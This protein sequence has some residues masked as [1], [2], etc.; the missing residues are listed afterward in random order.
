MTK[1]DS[2]VHQQFHHR[3][4][5][6][7]VRNCFR[8]QTY[9]NFYSKLHYTLFR[10]SKRFYIYTFLFTIIITAY[11]S[12]NIEFGV[13]YNLR[14]MKPET[15]SIINYR[16]KLIS[17]QK[18]EQSD[19]YNW[20]QQLYEQSST[21]KLFTNNQS[22]FYNYIN[23]SVST[24]SDYYLLNYNKTTTTKVTQS[25]MIVITI[26]YSSNG[27]DRQEGKF[28]IGQVLKT[29]LE[30]YDDPRIIV[31][32]CENS[33]YND[34]QLQHI[35]DE[36]KLIRKLVPVYIVNAQAIHTHSLNIELNEYEREKQAHLK[37]LKANF[38]SFT[39]SDYVLLLQDDA[40]PIDKIFLNTLLYLIDQRFKQW[41]EKP[42]FLKIYHPRW[43]I[44]YAKHPSVYIIVQLLAM[45]LLLTFIV[46]TFLHYHYYPT[47]I[48]DD[49]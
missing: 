41:K 38:E 18:K 2:M 23:T 48:V 26:L 49:T 35:G 11:V 4:R 5:T 44:D 37:C 36:I 32:I 7:S 31:T 47:P 20:L 9:L 40:K 29:L 24:S 30:Q 45:S 6:I 39:S 8:I 12:Y 22:T 27:N 21:N 3:S 17:K 19:A 15:P 16:Q 28:Y 13:L 25:D 46:Y 43:L 14:H 33:H 1:Y 42:A 34:E 10:W